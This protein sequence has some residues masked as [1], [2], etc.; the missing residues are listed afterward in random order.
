MITI[1][2][3][4]RRLIRDWL[5]SVRIDDGR[6]PIA[7]I[8]DAAIDY[9]CDQAVDCFLAQRIALIELGHEYTLSGRP[10]EFIVPQIGLSEVE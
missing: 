5:Q 6:G 9:W 1:N 3:I 7:L 10:E 2:D 4:G 8:D